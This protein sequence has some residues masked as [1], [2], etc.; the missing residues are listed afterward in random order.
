MA[1][2]KHKMKTKLNQPGKRKSTF[3]HI[4]V[5]CCQPL[6]FYTKKY[7][8]VN[9]C[10]L[11]PFS[12]QSSDLYLDRCCIYFHGSNIFKPSRDV[13]NVALA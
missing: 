13:T 6:R 7:H 10:R 11:A 5:C 4:A 9:V 1:L 3:E 12:V 2:V 8:T